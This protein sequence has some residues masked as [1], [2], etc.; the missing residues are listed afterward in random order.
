M[1]LWWHWAAPEGLCFA[2]VGEIGSLAGHKRVLVPLSCHL[3][4]RRMNHESGGRPGFVMGKNLIDFGA[5]SLSRRAHVLH[6]RRGP[7][8]ISGE[9][10][11]PYSVNNRGN[12]GRAPMHRVDLHID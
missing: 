9:A 6:R 5:E 4:S 12:V 11:V 10:V 3:L 7:R 8:R 2:G 1:Q